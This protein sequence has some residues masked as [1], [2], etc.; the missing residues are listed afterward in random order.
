MTELPSIAFVSGS[1]QSEGIFRGNFQVFEAL[2]SQGAIA[3]WVQCVDPGNMDD[4]FRG[5]E[6]IVGWRFPV[7]SLEM[8]MNRLWAFPR[9]LG[10]RT[11]DRVYLGDPTF[12]RLARGPLAS[13][14]IV[15]VHDLRPLT[16]YGDRIGTRW[17]FRYALP[18]LNRV[19]RVA[20]YT[21]FMRRELEESWALPEPPYV[22]SPH[23]SILRATGEAH[24]R[25]SE[26][27]IT[28]PGTVRVLYVATDRPYKNLEHFFSLARSLARL[29]RPQ[30]RF[31]LVSRLR[32]STADALRRDPIPNLE[33]IPFAED[34]GAIYWNSDILAF[35]SLYEGF[36]LPLLEAMSN[37]MPVVSTD[38]DPMREVVGAG[39]TLVAAEDHRGWVESLQS[40]GEASAYHRAGV[41]ALE[42]ADEF[43]PGRFLKKLPGL[44]E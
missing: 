7:R 18:L 25:T 34:L 10:N 16:P 38:R 15:R 3:R 19:R 32:A 35:P 39:G 27:R 5:G 37:G 17:M 21:E 31:V 2:R 11:E 12:L 41:R 36:G 22:L 29:T 43:S 30:F 26:D 8:G 13:R 44:L 28:G 9:R 1:K 24:L 14:I 6:T 42:R 40:L 20:V 4:Q 33:V 23:T